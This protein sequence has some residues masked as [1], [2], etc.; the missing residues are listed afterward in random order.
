M[1]KITL[2]KLKRFLNI[3]IVLILTAVTIYQG[4]K[5]R[6]LQKEMRYLYDEVLFTKFLTED[7]DSD[8]RYHIDV[9]SKE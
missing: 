5:I 3:T 1:I 9:D 7:L 4:I 2:S 8:F 6:D